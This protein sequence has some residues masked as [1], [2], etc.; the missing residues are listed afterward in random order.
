MREDR[1]EITDEMIENWITEQT[2]KANDISQKI[3]GIIGRVASIDLPAVIFSLDSI[4]NVYKKEYPREAK[5]AN[6]L[7]KRIKTEVT[8]TK[9]YTNGRILIKKQTL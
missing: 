5:M 2:G 9:E 7:G 4:A 8:A 6:E 1:I 3:A